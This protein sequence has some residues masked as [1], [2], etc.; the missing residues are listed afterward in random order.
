MTRTAVGSLL[1]SALLLATIGSSR[2]APE[3][4]QPN[5]HTRPAGTLSKG[6]LS[7]AL[8]TRRGR[9]LPEGDGG[10]SLDSVY[11][12]AE[13]GRAP[14]APGPMIR[15]PVGTAVRGTLHNTLT[16]PLIVF[17]LGK[18]RGV[19]DSLVIEAG[20]TSDF[21][22]TADQAGTFA[23]FARTHIDPV[24]G[25]DPT[26]QALNGAIIVDR[27]NAPRDRVFGISWNISVDPKSANGVA[28]AT[29]TI[30]GLSWPHTERLAYAQGDSIHWRVINFTEFDHPMHLHGFYFRVDSHGDS[31]Y[32][33]AQRRMAVTEV[34]NSFEGVELSWKADRPGNWVFHCHYAIHI[35]DF[36]TL[37]MKNGALDAAE[38]SHHQANAPH[39][40]HGLVMGITVT[41]KGP[42]V[43][44]GAPERNIRI[45]QRE[46]PNVYGKQ[47]G[48]AFAV[49]KGGQPSDTAS[50]PIPAPTLV[51]ERGKRVQV[52]IVNRSNQHAA[53]HWHGIELESYPDGVPGWS[54][55]GTQ[56]LP[57]IAP[58]DSLSVRWT[59]PRAGSFMYH[60]HFNEAKQ[61]GGGL[62]GPIIVLEPG[63][64]YNPETDR[65]LF[66]GTAGYLVTFVEAP[67]KVVL[68][69]SVAP[70]PM[71]LKANTKY[72]FRLF[73]LAGDA[74]TEVRLTNDATPVNWRAVAKD[75][76]PLPASQATSRPARLIFDPGE[77]YDFEFTPTQRGDLTL[78]FGLPQAPPPAPQSLT[79]V[80]VHVR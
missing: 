31:L 61:M 41:P 71:E 27:P 66:F 58:N 33:A 70:G 54:G 76:Y 5:D 37:D 62:Y 68:N 73:N 78:S 79:N 35:S 52:T 48:M 63:E 40:M 26:E 50:I 6:V 44:A 15:V 23:Y 22:F 11:A 46:R 47:P 19:A 12:F 24:V 4:I 30:N 53:V 28:A 17:G 10:K 56:L 34:L 60:S 45:E 69:G 1:T 39:Q 55:S 59:P 16:R 64:K 13:V 51:L 38:Q 43:V 25:R 67:P 65:T 74:P 57:S 80:V 8:E 2:R 75:G 72:R 9:W 7:L 42:Q 49:T 18:R 3:T 29:M 36:V 77:I 14:S 32:S 21:A 20:A